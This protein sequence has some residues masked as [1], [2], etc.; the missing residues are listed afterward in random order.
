M[1]LEQFI[2]DMEAGGFYVITHDGI[3]HSP[4]EYL[5]IYCESVLWAINEIRDK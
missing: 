5:K 3:K 1:D 2:E 4:R